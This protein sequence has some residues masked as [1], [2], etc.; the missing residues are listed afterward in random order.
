M[1]THDDFAANEQLAH[2]ELASVMRQLRQGKLDIARA[3]RTPS[4][5]RG[6]DVVP[7][8]F[9]IATYL[10]AAINDRCGKGKK[11]ANKSE[12]IR[13]FMV[14][15]LAMEELLDEE[16]VFDARL[17]Q[18]AQQDADDQ[19]RSL[20]ETIEACA[21]ALANADGDPHRQ[22]ILARLTELR[23]ICERN[24]YIDHMAD[25]DNAIH[26]KRRR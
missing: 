3:I 10:D 7:V 20:D 11:F 4:Q 21:K 22:Q 13:H 16:P 23:D 9:K 12:F 19:L 17:I 24:G 15:G 1:T 6:R 18:A 5:D 14:I 8:S 2:S 25:I 26:S